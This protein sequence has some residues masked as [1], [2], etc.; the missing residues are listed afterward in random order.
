MILTF[1]I[2]FFGI[3]SILTTNEDPVLTQVK[4][5]Y[6]TLCENPPAGM[7]ELKKQVIISGFYRKHGEIGYNVNKGHEIGLCLDG[8]V[9][10]VFHVLIHELAHTVSEKY[11][12]NEEFWKNFEIIKNHCVAI[13]IYK[14][15]PSSKK[16]CG[17][18]IRD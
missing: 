17:K 16:F 5:K 15:I 2:I 9:N 14:P 12:H 18:Y 8:T 1:I 11:S 4:E 3:L 10:D 6:R 7:E 13:G